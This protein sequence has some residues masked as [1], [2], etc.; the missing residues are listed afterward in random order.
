MKRL[1]TIIFSLLG[2][3]AIATPRLATAADCTVINS[4]DTG[5][6]SLRDCIDNVAT[7][8]GDVVTIDPSV[9]TPIGLTSGTLDID[10]GITIQ[11]AGAAVSVIDGSGNG[12]ARMFH[13]DDSSPSI[14]VN[15][16]GLTLQGATLSEVGAAMYLDEATVNLRD[17]IVQG[18]TSNS[19]SADGGAI[20]VDDQGIL[21]VNNCEFINNQVH[22]GGDGGAIFSNGSLFI[23]NSAFSTNT[24]EVGAVGSGGAIYLEG[25]VA[26]IRNT[27]FTGN[28]ADESGGAVYHIS[29]NDLT[30][31]NSTFG[32]NS[33]GNSRGGAVYHSSGR[34]FL[35]NSDFTN[36]D[37]LL[38]AAGAVQISDFAQI[39]NCF[40]DGNT[41]FN[42]DG[43]AIHNDGEMILRNSTFTNNSVS[44][45]EGGAIYVDTEAFIE[46]CTIADNQASDTGGSAHGGGISVNSES[47]II[48]TTIFNN[49]AENDGGGLYINDTVFVNNLTVANNVA[50]GEGGGIFNNDTLTFSNSIISGNTD[51]GGAPD[52][53]NASTMLS[54]GPNLIQDQTGCDIDGDPSQII[55][56]DP[57]L[58]SALADNGGPG[59]GRD[60]ANPT[61]TLALEDGSPALEAGD[62]VSCAATDQR[63]TSRPQ[64]T[65][66]DLGAYE[67]GP[68]ADLSATSLIFDEQAVGTTSG[69][70]TITLTNNGPIP[71]TINGISVGGTN[72]GDFAQTNDC[73]GSVAPGGAC[74]I[75]ATFTPSDTGVR[76]ADITVDSS[77]NVQV[78]NL[79]GSGILATGGGGCSLNMQA[80]AIAHPATLLLITLV[81]G[82]LW[83][84]RK[85]I[86]N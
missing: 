5:T 66:C 42:D 58:A 84:I 15:I 79:L 12:D 56:D 80:N 78:I 2:L 25:G 32:D 29:G 36:N 52:C 81:V 60:G 33:S 16:S 55:N 38:A 31:V 14:T 39:E 7:D 83:F 51:T 53:L 71:L 34:L 67:A 48:N 64:G 47:T 3:A 20:Y 22:D 26:F 50:G 73:G 18:N 82:G 8:D 69:V 57:L 44:E 75:G 24:T 41:G 63:G 85:K 59:I 23:D 40:F 72:A 21:T 17:C 74:N 13:I 68:S 4:D 65:D 46:N 9:T 77:A 70:Q 10:A 1:L 76:S 45:G 6:G 37:A 49:Q 30:I 28:T 86:L 62:N 19:A 61:L 27:T 11:G 54:S 35:S 43:G